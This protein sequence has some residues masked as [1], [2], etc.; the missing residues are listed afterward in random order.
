M[1]TVMTQARMA[2]PVCWN[3]AA[4]AHPS[5]CG[6][7][8]AGALRKRLENSKEKQHDDRQLHQHKGQ[9]RRQTAFSLS[10]LFPFAC[11]AHLVTGALGH[12]V[13]LAVVL[14]HVG[15][16]EV[17]DIGPD[18]HR[19]HGGEGGGLLGHSLLGEDGHYGAGR[20]G[21]GWGWGREGLYLLL[22]PDK[23]SSRPEA[24]REPSESGG[25]VTEGTLWGVL[26]QGAPGDAS[27]I[28]MVGGDETVIYIYIFAPATKSRNFTRHNK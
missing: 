9:P 25:G 12:G 11:S 2:Q 1:A 27:S 18:G 26:I 8:R 19:E 24:A 10:L 16:H 28:D 6:C 17:H 13:R 15:V 5:T 4:T 3:A 21:W 14:G 22:I 23:M 20:H 7:P